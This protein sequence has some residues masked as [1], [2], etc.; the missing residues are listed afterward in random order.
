MSERLPGISDDERAEEMTSF[1][2]QGVGMP[3]PQPVSVVAQAAIIREARGGRREE[4][5]RC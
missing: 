4:K 2:E 3:E 5:P 1:V